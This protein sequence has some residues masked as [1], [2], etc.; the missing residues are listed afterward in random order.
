MGVLQTHDMPAVVC[1]QQ[2]EVPGCGMS[3]YMGTVRD[4]QIHDVFKQNAT[5]LTVFWQVA[6]STMHTQGAS[7]VIF[8]AEAAHAPHQIRGVHTR[9]ELA[10]GGHVPT[11][12]RSTFSIRNGSQTFTPVPHLDENAAAL[13]AS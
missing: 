7:P 5:Y 8:V 6:Y 4:A 1:K 12:A 2:P 11:P 13:K 3:I 10:W 9:V